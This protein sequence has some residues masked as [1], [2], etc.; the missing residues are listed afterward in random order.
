MQIDGKII[1]ITGAS[2]GIGAACAAQFQRRG[3]KLSLVARNETKL[4]EVG[5]R[6]SVITA[7]DI[8]DPEVRKRAVEAT[9]ERF[10]QIDILINNA[11]V[12]LYAPSWQAPLEEV[13]KMMELNFFSALGMIQQV[14]PRMKARRSGCI[15]NVGSIAGKVTLPWLTLYSASKYALGSLTD[16]LRMELHRDGIHAITVCPGYV[17]TGFQQHILLGRV[18]DAVQRTNMFRITA[19]QCAEAIARGVEKNARTVVTPRA[20]WAF[21]ILERLFPSLIDDRL[22]EMNFRGLQS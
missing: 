9:I 13:R 10:G 15:V 17:S 21:I 2:E 14:V 20:G 7:G 19:E 5:G 11:G 16:G 3:A 1:L 4:R 6:D 18:P 12:G 22:E 8:T